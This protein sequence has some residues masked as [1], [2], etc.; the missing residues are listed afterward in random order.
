MIRNNLVPVP[1]RRLSRLQCWIAREEIYDYSQLK[2]NRPFPSS[3]VS[4][5]MKARLSAK[6]FHMGMPARFLSSRITQLTS[7]MN[8][9]FTGKFKMR[10]LPKE[11]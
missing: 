1:V 8:L 4:L 6:A 2:T 3:R 9:W 11:N 10:K 7:M 5:I